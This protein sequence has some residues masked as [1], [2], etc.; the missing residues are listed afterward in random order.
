MKVR[1]GSWAWL[2][3]SELTSSALQA[4]KLQLTITPKQYQASEDSEDPIP[5]KLYEETE[6]EL[7][8]AREFFYAKRRKL[9]GSPEVELDVT[10][11][12]KSTWPGPFEFKG[13]LRA[14]Q[15]KAVSVTSVSFRGGQLGGMVQALPGWGKTVFTCGLIASLQ[16]PTLVLVHKEFLMSQWLE[17][18]AQ[19]LPEAQVGIAQQDRCE[20]AGRHIVVGMIHSVAKGNMPKAFYNWPG[21]VIVDEAHRV[22]ARTWAPAPALFRAKYRLGV[23]ATPRRKDG[24][25]DV[26]RYHLG[27]ILF[28]GE[29]QRLK[30]SIK[31]VFTNFKLVK[32]PYLNPSL[33]PESLILKFLC[34]NEPRNQRI[35][36]LMVDA[37]RAGRK[38][39]VLSKR[40][41]HLER[42]D[43]M[44][45]RE[46][47][48]R[49]LGGPISTGYYI[50][51][52]TEEARDKSSQAQVIFATSQFASEGL[53]IPALDT[54]FLVNPI[55]D[56]EQAVGRIQRP[57]E[58]KKPPIVV[59]FR[60]PAVRLFESYAEARERLYAKIT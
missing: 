17:R 46:W 56:V 38:L 13:K 1:V 5:I 15:E 55:G 21:L 51:G 9:L 16:I 50:G 4:I 48:E 44:F 59:D 25:E 3:K 47:K 10:E 53:D 23:T 7:G 11:G 40:I 20:Y 6:T 41:N 8:V 58:G 36:E 49:K 28:K 2:P 39:I 26:F 34:S 33:A 60:D 27:P 42:L 52:M 35:V 22:S 29:E 24:T 37:V 14:E 45:K 31:R 12:D 30:V 32:T 43:S 54:L 19:Y 57:F 18:I